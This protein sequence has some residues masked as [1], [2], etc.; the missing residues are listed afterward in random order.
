MVIASTQS[1]R[2]AQLNAK[3][4]E[5]RRQYWPD[6]P[7]AAL[8]HRKESKG[9]ITIPRVLPI[10]LS[11]MDDM[12]KNRPLSSTY[13]VLWC[14]TFDENMVTTMSPEQMAFEAGFGGQR[15]AQTWKSRMQ[16]LADLGFIMAQP[17]ANGPFS[18]VLILNPVLVIRRH[19]ETRKAK[20]LD[21]KFNALASRASEIG[22]T[23]FS[24]PLR[25]KK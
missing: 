21:A 5:L 22:A 1:A 13:F 14:R 17:G 16:I 9:F 20:V 18:H 15:G 23:D 11:I 12:S 19:R 24:I 2:A 10:V 25:K 3:R 6:V 8:W 4:L 7:E